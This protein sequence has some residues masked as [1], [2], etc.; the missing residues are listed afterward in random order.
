MRSNWAGEVVAY[1]GEAKT[2]GVDF[3][4]AWHNALFHHPPRGP[5]MGR[6]QLS[7]EDTEETLVDFFRR[8]TEDAWHGRRPVLR[9][10]SVDLLDIPTSESL[11]PKAVTS[12]HG[13]FS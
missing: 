2:A 9:H 7:F 3:D 13:N 12:M 10:L 11:G 1:L 5:G 6:R 8:V 4:T